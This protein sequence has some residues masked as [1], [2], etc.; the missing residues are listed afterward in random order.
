M[1]GCLAVQMRSSRNFCIDVTLLVIILGIAAYLYKC[2]LP[3]F[4]V[5]I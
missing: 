3:F 2:V 5:S 1:R 4:S